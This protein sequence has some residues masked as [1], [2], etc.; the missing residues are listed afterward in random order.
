MSLTKEE[1][2]AFR[3]LLFKHQDGIAIT[4]IIAVLERHAVFG[5]LT[6]HKKTSISEIL[7]AHPQ[8]HAGYLNIA[9]RS[10]ASQGILT[11]EV[12]PQEVRIETTSKFLAFQRHSTHY[13]RFNELFEYYYK[14]F[15][16]PFEFPLQ[17]PQKL[18]E[19]ASYFT[20]ARNTLR[21]DAY[22]QVEVAAHLE[23]VILAPLLVYLS[24]HGNLEI[25]ETDT[26]LADESLQKVLKLLAL[27]DGNTLTAKGFFLFDKSYAYG[28]TVSYI[29]IMY[30]METYLT[31]DFFPFFK[32]DHLGND[33]DLS[34]GI[35]DFS[36]VT[37]GVLRGP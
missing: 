28:V 10:L 12:T 34:H 8:F 20:N 3:S 24:Y 17:H 5:F 23:G 18:Y 21:T 7:K 16:N 25:I 31:G 4:A 14:L 27:H 30:Y 22:F 35:E 2:R 13:V 6:T 33:K 36:H 11:Y 1:K 15:K 26:F 29:P 19:L 9:L 37:H 32:Q